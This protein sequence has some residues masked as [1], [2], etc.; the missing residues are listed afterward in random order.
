MIIGRVMNLT[1]AD[2]IEWGTPDPQFLIGAP[3]RFE[4]A[5]KMNF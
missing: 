2:Y 3:R 1:D 5:L 4:V